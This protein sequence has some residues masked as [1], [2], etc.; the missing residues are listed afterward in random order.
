[1]ATLAVIAGT[2]Q[3]V[4]PDRVSGDLS[5]YGLRVVELVVP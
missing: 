2:G 4:G 3:D 5:Q 1:V